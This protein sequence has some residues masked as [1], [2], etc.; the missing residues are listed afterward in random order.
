MSDRHTPRVRI[1][2]SFSFGCDRLTVVLLQLEK[3]LFS[4]ET[5]LWSLK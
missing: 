3:P 1:P 4:C 2:L 5:L